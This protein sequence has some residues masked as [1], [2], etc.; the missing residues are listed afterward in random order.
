L[1]ISSM[2]GSFGTLCGTPGFDV[3]MGRLA[4]W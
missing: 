3:S 4:R 1:S 2:D